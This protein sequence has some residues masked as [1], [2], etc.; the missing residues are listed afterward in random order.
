[1]QRSRSIRWQHRS[2]ARTRRDRRNAVDARVGRSTRGTRHHRDHD[3][4]GPAPASAARSGDAAAL[5]RAAVDA[6]TPRPPARPPRA[7]LKAPSS[8]PGRSSP[9]RARTVGA[10]RWRRERDRVTS[11]RDPPDSMCALSGGRL[12]DRQRRSRLAATRIAGD[13]DDPAGRHAQRLAVHGARAAW[14]AGPRSRGRGL[15]GSW[16]RR[17]RI[18][19]LVRRARRRPCGVS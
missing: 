14:R 17:P 7:P 2:L 9:G 10:A 15:R 1:M 16:W 5:R 19:T 8:A 11:R 3:H 4:R 18:P 6:G 12:H 13:V